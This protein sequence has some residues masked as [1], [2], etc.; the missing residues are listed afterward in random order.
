MLYGQADGVN[1]TDLIDFNDF[2]IGFLKAT[3]IGLVGK[4]PSLAYPGNWQDVVDAAAQSGEGFFEGKA[5]R[6][7]VADIALCRPDE[8]ITCRCSVELSGY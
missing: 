6:V 3:C 5:E 4:A 7:P 8:L 1:H 2:E